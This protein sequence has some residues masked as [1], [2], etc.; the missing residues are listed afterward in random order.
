MRGEGWLP[1]LL[2]QQDVGLELLAAI[3]QSTRPD[4]PRLKLM[5]RKSGLKRWRD[6]YVSVARE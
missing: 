3:F 5:Q 1:L 4:C 6:R 2:N